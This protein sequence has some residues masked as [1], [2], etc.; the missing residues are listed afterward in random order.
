MLVAGITAFYG[1]LAARENA[2]LEGL[3]AREP[4]P[5]LPL[6]RVARLERSTWLSLAT[7]LLLANC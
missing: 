5:P 3:P 7:I 2:L 6:A 1:V 4:S